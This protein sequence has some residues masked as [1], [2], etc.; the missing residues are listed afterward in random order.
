MKPD[1]DTLGQVPAFAALSEADRR[2]LAVC[3]RGR[4]YP[5]GVPV[6]REGDPGHSLFLVGEGTLVATTRAGGMLRELGRYGAGEVLGATALVERAPRP[7]TVTT[8]GATT[9]F[10]LDAEAIDLLRPAAPAAAH[11]LLGAAIRGLLGR[12]RRLEQRVE[13]ELERAGSP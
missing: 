3:F 6:F 7:A 2:A 12:L 8:L 1:A 13:Q 11:A 4:R 5:T 10:E 9:V